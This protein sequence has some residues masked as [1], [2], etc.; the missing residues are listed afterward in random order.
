MP[1]IG[2]NNGCSLREVLAE[3]HVA[4]AAVAVL[5]LW[6]LD[7]GFKALWGPLSRIGT[8][9]F[10]AIAILDIPYFSFSPLDRF[11][12]ITSLLYAAGALMSLAAAWFL[13]HW[14]HGMG[15]IGTLTTYRPRLTKEKQCS[16]A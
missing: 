14:V 16:T 8:F 6:S 10:T 4:G 3:S 5:L 15:P 2:R 13:S 12:L 9:L 7:F 11:M 1:T